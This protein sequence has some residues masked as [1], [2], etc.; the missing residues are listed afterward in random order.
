VLFGEKLGQNSLL[1][2]WRIQFQEARVARP[3]ERHRSELY[4]SEPIPERQRAAL[5]EGITI[6]LTRNGWRTEDF[7][8]GQGCTNPDFN[9][10]LVLNPPSI[11]INVLNDPWNALSRFDADLLT[12]SLAKGRGDANPD[13]KVRIAS[14]FAGRDRVDLQETDYFSSLMT[15][16]QAWT[17]VRTKALQKDGMTPERVLWDGISAFID[18]ATGSLKGFSDALISN[19]LGA[20]TLAFSADGYLMIVHQNDNNRQSANTLAP[21]GSGSLDWSD[22]LNS[23]ASDFLALVKYGA[24]RELREECAL[25]DDASRRGNIISK[26]KITS[27]VRMLHRAGKPE[28]YCLGLLGATAD[29]IRGRKPERYVEEVLKP[30]MAHAIW[31]IGRPSSEIARVCQAYLDEVLR[32]RQGRI[33]LSYPLEHALKLTIELCQDWQA[34][35]VL[36]QFIQTSL[37][38]IGSE[39][40]LR[41][42]HK[43]T[44]AS[45]G[46]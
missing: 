22:V 39:P 45:A 26:I 35:P 40:T 23:K 19:Q 32:H 5:T 41:R 4:T 17:C 37:K 33:P 14:D 21:S 38:E 2:Q 24:E 13:K 30:E 34:G 46:G 15:D 11:R 27:F 10:L 8:R 29:K 43:R 1:D 3:Q 28:F 20:S 44:D 12:F 25:D 36:D 42:N 9:R 31:N 16:Q 6:A 18:T 7:E